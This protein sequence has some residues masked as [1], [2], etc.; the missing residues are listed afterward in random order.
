[1][2]LE[3]ITVPVDKLIFGVTEQQSSWWNF[4]KFEET[5]R[6]IDDDPDTPI[7][8]LPLYENWCTVRRK[9]LHD[10]VAPAWGINSVRRHVAIY[11]DIRDNGFRE[12]DNPIR[13]RIDNNGLIRIGN[14]H[15]RVSMLRHLKYKEVRVL[16]KSRERE[17][18]KFKEQL[19]SLYNKKF[20]YQPTDHP[21]LAHW[22]IN[23]NH[24]HSV[25]E[26][27]KSSMDVKGK[28]VLDI[29]SCTGWFSYWLADS[30]A[31]VDGVDVNSKRVEIANYQRVYRGADKNNP[32]FQTKTFE[33]QLCGNIRYDAVLLLNVIHH[34]IRRNE[35]QAFQALKQISEHTDMLF[36]QLSPRIQI[37][38]PDF[39]EKTLKTTRF[40]TC[41]MKK[42]SEKERPTLLFQ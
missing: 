35:A 26:F 19:H 40:K 14:G 23:Y 29:G 16:V 32:R 34:Y 3:F 36:I 33:K 39:I 9:I 25:L 21:D 8:E 4:D 1:M 28:T 38:I 10:K 13:V 24:C 20:L 5:W 42:L 30:G 41:T 22:D 11:M 6:I 2:N 12:D 7:E 18:L 15:H 17:F 37:T 27:I 31:L